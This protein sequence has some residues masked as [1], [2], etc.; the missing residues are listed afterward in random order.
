[1]WALDAGWS[2]A[3]MALN[4]SK[5]S[6]GTASTASPSRSPVTV[7]ISRTASPLSLDGEPGRSGRGPIRGPSGTGRLRRGRARRANAGSVA[8]VAG[9]AGAARWI[10]QQAGESALALVL[11]HARRA[12]SGGAHTAQSQTQQRHHRTTLTAHRS[13]GWQRIGL[14]GGALRHPRRTRDRDE[15]TVASDELL[16]QPGESGALLGD[17]LRGRVRTAVVASEHQTDHAVGL[18]SA[19]RKTSR[20]ARPPRNASVPAPRAPARSRLSEPARG[21]CGRC[22]AVRPLRWLN[23]LSCVCYLVMFL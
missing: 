20:S 4:G 12:D 17:G 11:D 21:R 13:V 19:G 22:R 10:G 16:P 14:G 15:W 18:G 6:C 8:R 9:H 7:A 1:M 2:I 3:K 5:F 23:G